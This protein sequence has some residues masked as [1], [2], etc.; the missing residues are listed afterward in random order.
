MG[1]FEDELRRRGLEPVIVKLAED[2]ASAAARDPK[3]TVG[4]KNARQKN[5]PTKRNLNRGP[6][7][8][9]RRRRR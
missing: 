2:P 6:K 9:G 4:S 7:S 3:A 1:T 5:L 8:P